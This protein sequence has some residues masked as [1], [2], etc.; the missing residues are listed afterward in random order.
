MVSNGELLMNF[1]DVFERDFIRKVIFLKLLRLLFPQKCMKVCFVN[2]ILSMEH[3][4][5]PI[6]I[7]F[8]TLN[9]PEGIM[10]TALKISVVLN[11][12]NFVKKN[13]F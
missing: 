4:M 2:Q 13:F 10:L 1:E 9:Q 8:H 5:E 3:V 6:R 11:L 7:G 12:V